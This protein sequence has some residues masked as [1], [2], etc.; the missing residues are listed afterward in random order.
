VAGTANSTSAASRTVVAVPKS[1]TAPRISGKATLGRRLSAVHG[2][3][4]WAPTKF[5]Y[6][7]LRC[8]ASGGRCVAIKKATRATYRVASKDAGHRLRLRV[9][10][11]NAA[12]AR[13]ASSRP[14][15]RVR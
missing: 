4:T 12:G 14:T 7:W 15:A 5:R 1:T 3:W 11:T 8:S 13:S 9:T 2:K 6:Q 10:A